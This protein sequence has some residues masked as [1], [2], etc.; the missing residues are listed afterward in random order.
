MSHAV[1]HGRWCHQ[2]PV[3]YLNCGRNASPSL[4]PDP[5][6]AALVQEAFR[7][8]AGGEAPVAVHADLVGRGFTTRRGGPVGRQT[9]YSM[10]RKVVYK[11]ELDTELG[12]SGGDWEPLVEAAVW[13]RAQ[14]TV[15]SV[16]LRDPSAKA[17]SRSG[18]RPYR[19]VRK[20]F[21]LRGLL[22]CAVCRR[23][24]SGGVS[25]GYH[26]MNC[27]EGHVRVRA[28]ALNVG[29]C[30]WLGSVRPNQVLLRRLEMSI[31]R[32]LETEQR[33]VAQRRLLK[34]RAAADIKAKISKISRALADGTMEGS[35]YRATYR[36]LKAELQTVEHAD[37]EDGLEQ[38]DVDAVLTFATRLLSKPERWWQEASP[39]DKIRLQQ[40]LFPDGLLIDPAL[41]I[42]TDPSSHDSVTY[43]LFGGG[44]SDLASPRGVLPFTVVGS[45]V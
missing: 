33:S 38:L 35:A 12:A 23:R 3:G 9:F 1:E 32:E 40:A 7:R 22:R 2:A 11:A 30:E 27:P 18:K 31:R 45:V 34:Q 43:L 4:R 42:S 6:R 16:A 24:I 36:E 29:F 19:R 17:G 44:A 10:I 14:S 21:E 26:Y 41:E 8:L 37:V 15:S 39:E 25:K 20:G 13:E 28:E 5:E